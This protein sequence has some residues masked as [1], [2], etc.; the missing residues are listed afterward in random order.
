[1]RLFFAVRLSEKVCREVARLQARLREAVGDRG[2]RWTPPEQ[3][4]YT[5]RFLGETPEVQ[6]TRAIE[7]AWV[8]ASQVAPFSLGLGGI[9]AFPQQRRPQIIWVGATEGVPLL[10]RLAESLER[11]LAE[12]GFAPETRRFNPH[13]T[14]AR[15]RTPEGQEAVAKTLKSTADSLKKVDKIKVIPIEDFVL[16]R[17]ELR[18]AGAVYTVQETFPLT[19]I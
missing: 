13:L 7:A 1:M 10:T 4:H 9:G 11:G 5:L 12:R 8:V 6:R 15:I 18:P 19:T 14:L 16:M 3:F 2:I 17:S